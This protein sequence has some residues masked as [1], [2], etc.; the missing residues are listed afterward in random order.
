MATDSVQENLEKLAASYEHVGSV[1]E[2]AQIEVANLPVETPT[3]STP[4]ASSISTANRP[5]P[6]R[7]EG[8]KFVK[9]AEHPAYLVQLAKQAGMTEDDIASADSEA[10]GMAIMLAGSV[11]RNDHVAAN[12]EAKRDADPASPAPVAAPKEPKD[13]LDEIIAGFDDE[14]TV[15][16]LRE[17][18]K[19]IK[20]LRSELAGVKGHI[21]QQATVSTYNELDQEFNKSPERYGVGSHGKM[22][23]GPELRRRQLIVDEMKRLSPNSK[24][25]SIAELYREAEEIIFGSSPVP[26]RSAPAAPVEDA[27]EIA[28]RKKDFAAGTLAEP[29]HRN[30]SPEPRSR[31]SAIRAV[32]ALQRQSLASGNGSNLGLSN[33]IDGGA[34]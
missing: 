1:T 15:K 9:K 23:D 24:A 32:E 30:S 2:P 28:A 5:L 22:K 25:N 7:G 10:L 13:E 18:R 19:E 26:S 34:P 12:I 27:P 21:Q 17:M 14:G 8:G 3:E 33:E 6:P 31:A 16:L 20:E 4:E 29:T 11:R